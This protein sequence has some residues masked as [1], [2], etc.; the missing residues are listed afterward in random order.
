M[1]SLEGIQGTVAA[2]VSNHVEAEERSD[3]LTSLQGIVSAKA[4]TDVEVDEM[5][6]RVRDRV[7]E[8]SSLNNDAEIVEVA[9]AEEHGAL[10][11]GMVAGEA[12]GEEGETHS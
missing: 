1:S 8:R 11:D 7:M 4:S 3:T 2:K 9:A 10:D 12:K 6:D 5:K